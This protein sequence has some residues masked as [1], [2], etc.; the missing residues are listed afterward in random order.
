[1]DSVPAFKVTIDGRDITSKIRS[2]LVSL[3]LT[4]CRGEESD[5]LDLTLDDSDGLLAI[6]RRGAEISVFLGWE[7]SPAKGVPA[8][9][10]AKGSFTVDEAEHHGAPDVITLRA[11]AADL[12]A[13]L[14]GLK[15]RSWHQRRV[16]DIVGTI[17][18]EH[19]LQA[20]I[21]PALNTRT[22][23][24]VDQTSESDAN[25]LR[26]LGRQYDAVATIKN[27][28]LL[29]LP[30]SESKTAAGVD[31]SRVT[32]MRRDGDAHRYHT[33]SRDAYTGVRAYWHDPKRSNRRGVL[34]GLS[35]GAKRLRT[36]FANRQDAL[37]AATAEWQRIQRGAATFSCTLAYGRAD[38]L[39]QSPVTV[40]GFKADIDATDWIVVRLRHELTQ[41]GF[42]TE[43]ECEVAGADGGQALRPI[44]DDS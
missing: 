10:V 7:I 41:G 39:P 37:A 38:I 3:T 31:L 13:E 12:I 16:G 34:V 27:G 43:I 33:A 18:R 42:T 36:T 40:Q 30:A 4:D 22:V 24:H 21:A 26:R 6:P 28:T 8:G 1:M 44:D 5:Q 35:G 15:D 32:L 20:R 17:A 23:D 2:R 25:F 14:R 19:G 29:F 9:I 11:R